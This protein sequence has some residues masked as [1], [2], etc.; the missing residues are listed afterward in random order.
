[1]IRKAK[2][3]YF[4][5]LNPRDPSKFWKTVKY[6]N[7]QQSVILALVQDENTASTDSQKAEVLNSF[8]ASCFNS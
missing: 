1:M 6:R 2:S 5:Q 8:F 7:K 3:E 4:L